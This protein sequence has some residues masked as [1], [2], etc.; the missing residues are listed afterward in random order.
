M[1]SC[2]QYKLE[3]LKNILNPKLIDMKL[4]HYEI[5]CK[6]ENIQEYNKIKNYKI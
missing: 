6:N 4:I 5:K 3:I 1:N 2:E